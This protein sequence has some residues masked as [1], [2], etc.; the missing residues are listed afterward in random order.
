VQQTTGVPE[1]RRQA[2]REDKNPPIVEIAL[3][4]VFVFGALA[5]AF[6]SPPATLIPAFGLM[7]PAAALLGHAANE[8]VKRRRA[9]PSAPGKERELLTAL[10]EGGGSLTAADVAMNTTLTVREA[11]QMLSELT[12]GGYLRVE[13]RDDALYYSLIG[14][15][16]PQEIGRQGASGGDSP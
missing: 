6:L 4:I 8:I 16:G 14:R 5:F 9:L 1:P 7:I 2:E 13:R 12:S 3:G 11:D 10:R 15:Y